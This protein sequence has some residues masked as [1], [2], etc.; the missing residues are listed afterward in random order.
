MEEEQNVFIEKE[1]KE[2]KRFY[3]FSS[4]YVNHRERLKKIGYGIFIAF[5][6]V[7]LLFVAWTFFDTY[8]LSF[9]AERRAVA[10]VVLLGQDDLNAY[11]QANA[12][13]DLTNDSV[14]VIGIGDGKYDL[15]STITNPNTQWWVEATYTFT[16]GSDELATG[17]LFLLPGDEKPAIA[18]QVESE[19][20]PRNVEMELSE[21]MWHRVDVHEVGDYDVWFT[22]HQNFILEDVRWSTDDSLED[23]IGRVQFE[24]SNDTA[25]SYYDVVFYVLLKRGGRIVGV[26]QTSLQSFD[27]FETQD[28]SLSWFGTLPAVSSVDVIPEVAIFDV[29][30]YKPLEGE[31]TQDIRTRVFPRR[32]R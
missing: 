25:F 29:E 6:V 16:S 18:F 21:I 10:E 24:V 20:V 4:W 2:F 9:A 14:T 30:V 28:V 3:R 15:V 5:D 1:D 13:N 32:R 26:N 23:P 7:L 19:T 8:V 12:A 31:T 11:T 27:S 22:D 17:S